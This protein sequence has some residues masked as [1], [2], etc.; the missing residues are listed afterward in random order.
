MQCIWKAFSRSST[1][2]LGRVSTYFPRNKFAPWAS[3]HNRTSLSSRITANFPRNLNTA[4]LTSPS[5]FSP[6]S[7]EFTSLFPH[8]S[9]T[10]PP[11][12]LALS[13]TNAVH[14]ALRAHSFEDAVTIVNTVRY[15]TL[16][17]EQRQDKAWESIKR[18]QVAIPLGV[19][20]RVPAHALLH[21][22]VRNG[23]MQQASHIA[24]S[25]MTSG[26]RVRGRTLER[27]TDGL[28]KAA[29]VKDTARKTND[30]CLRNHM[31][32]LLTGPEILRLDFHRPSNPNTAFA[33]RLWLAARNSRSHRTRSMFNTLI[34]LCLINGEIIV[35]SLLFGLLVKDWEFRSK[36]LA[37]HCDETLPEASS[38]PYEKVKRFYFDNLSNKDLKP[39]PEMLNTIISPIEERLKQAT[40]DDVDSPAFQEALQA[41]AVLGAPL[42]DRQLPFSHVCNLLKALY[43]CP[44]VENWVWVMGT[45]GPIH[46]PAYEYYHRT[47]LH[48]AEK[49]PTHQPLHPCT[50]VLKYPK[51]ESLG[52]RRKGAKLIRSITF[53]P[54]HPQS[55]MQPPLGATSYTSLIHYALR[56]RFSPTLAK[57]I[58]EHMTVERVPP[59]PIT[60]QIRNVLLRAA[61]L[62]RQRDITGDIAQVLR[63]HGIEPVDHGAISTRTSSKPPRTIKDTFDVMQPPSD[64]SLDK[65]S[66]DP[67]TLSTYL[68]TLIS[69]G[70]PDMVVQAMRLLLPFFQID[71]TRR[72]AK[73]DD[74]LK[75]KW[76][77]SLILAM[78]FGPRVLSVFLQ[79]LIKGGHSRDAHALFTL[80]NCASHASQRVSTVKGKRTWRWRVPVAIYTQMLQVYKSEFDFYSRRLLLGERALYILLRNAENV[81]RMAKNDMLRDP[82][83]GARL[84]SRLYNAMLKI[85]S[86]TLPVKCYSIREMRFRL[87]EY[88]REYAKTGFVDNRGRVQL[89]EE[90][91]ADMTSAGYP[92]PLGFHH[93]FL[94]DGVG[95]M[96]SSHDLPELDRHPVCSRKSLTHTP[97]TLPV[98][99]RKLLPPRLSRR[100]IYN[101]YRSR[102]AKRS[103]MCHVLN[104]VEK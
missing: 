1:S 84:D 75:R 80:T 72:R 82:S 45:N 18:L 63:K 88:R 6:S 81:Y 56:H 102:K 94:T 8:S 41:L 59:L 53:T 101:M 36:S 96:D 25:M 57:Q 37:S 2:S 17:E 48:L 90:V 61:S 19:S 52:Q 78:E 74:N 64:I 66:K 13:A 9:Q 91:V 30:A 12:R 23:L 99:R 44:K 46:V 35:A 11:S 49:P 3:P 67:T 22:L 95:I 24:T 60:P 73:L 55:H 58:F 71:H 39:I 103:E 62:Y 85:L 86:Q 100:A 92:I 43:Q 89:L 68:S 15:A 28:A 38:K 33:L 7:A 42:N 5:E 47:L 79:A 54:P 51:P 76:K 77:E 98:S 69:C 104:R 4:T 20:P 31:E 87:V 32:G 50:F 14:M 26:I 21:G 27:I 93:L 34:T 10:S 16:P 65:I 40:P 70:Q 97:Y 83:R 29:T